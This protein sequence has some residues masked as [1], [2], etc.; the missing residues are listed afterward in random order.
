M[1]ACR[2]VSDGAGSR[3][4]TIKW[5]GLYS[6]RAALTVIAIY[7]ERIAASEQDVRWQAPQLLDIDF[8]LSAPDV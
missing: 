7:D 6:G 3:G 8:G 2:D 1:A 5:P 4:K